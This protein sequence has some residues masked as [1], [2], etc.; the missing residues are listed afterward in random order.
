MRSMRARFSRGLTPRTLLAS[1]GCLRVQLE[2]TFLF[3]RRTRYKNS[4]ESSHFSEVTCGLKCIQYQT[5]IVVSYCGILHKGAPTRLPCWWKIFGSRYIS[6][7]SQRFCDTNTEDLYIRSHL[8]NYVIILVLREYT[9]RILTSFRPKQ[10]KQD[11]LDDIKMSAK[12]PPGA[13]SKA[14]SRDNFCFQSLLNI[15]I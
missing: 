8:H 10:T 11:N 2:Y 14:R 15:L 9:K 12:S 13:H 6:S 3:P 7:A 4:V 5:Q 1:A